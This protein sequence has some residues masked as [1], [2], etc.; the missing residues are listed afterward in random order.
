MELHPDSSSPV[1]SLEQQWIDTIL[2]FH[3]SSESDQGQV[4]WNVLRQNWGVAEICRAQ[5]FAE[6]RPAFSGTDQKR[7]TAAG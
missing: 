2:C 5:S 1:L 4:L 7:H 6:F 3:V